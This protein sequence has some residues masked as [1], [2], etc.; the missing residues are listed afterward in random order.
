[1]PHFKF[2]K[3][4]AEAG[5]L[6]ILGR[7]LRIGRCDNALSQSRQPLAQGFQILFEMNYSRDRIP[8]F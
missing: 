4:L 1:M 3:Q 5:S 8:Q 2:Q 6:Q 7:L